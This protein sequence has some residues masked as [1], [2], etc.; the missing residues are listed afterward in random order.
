MSEL[1]NSSH[2]NLGIRSQRLLT[3]GQVTLSEDSDL[4]VRERTHH[5]MNDP[6]VIE[7]YHISLLPIMEIHQIR[8]NPWSLEPIDDSANLLQIVDHRTVG[9]MQLLHS[10]GVNLKRQPPRNGVLPRHRQDLD[11]ALVDRRKL[12]A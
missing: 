11:L 3:R 12:V 2:F 1:H 6:M 4:I 10:T 7:Q 8:G 5:R 9:E